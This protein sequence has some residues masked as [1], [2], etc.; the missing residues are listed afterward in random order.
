MRNVWSLVL[1]AALLLL[2]SPAKLS[3]YVD[4]GTGAMLWQL[5]AAAAIGSLFYIRRILAFFGLGAR[6]K[7]ET[8]ETTAGARYR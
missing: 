5:L 3:A 2:A 8:P 6:K 7:S 1:L 4:P